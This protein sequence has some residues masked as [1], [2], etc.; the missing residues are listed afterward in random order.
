MTERR[1]R[2]FDGDSG[3]A[4]ALP[5]VAPVPR[6]NMTIRTATE[7]PRSA[8]LTLRPITTRKMV[9]NVA[10]I[11]LDGYA[12]AERYFE[13]GERPPQGG[14]MWRARKNLDKATECLHESLDL[15]R[16]VVLTVQG[17]QK[18]V[19]YMLTL[20]AAEAIKANYSES[21]ESRGE[22]L[23]AVRRFTGE[24]KDMVNKKNTVFGQ[25]YLDR[26]L[27]GKHFWDSPTNIEGS[28][29]SQPGYAVE[30]QTANSMKITE[31]MHQYFRESLNHVLDGGGYK[32]RHRVLAI[33]DWNHFSRRAHLCQPPT[34]LGF[35]L[36]N[37]GLEPTEKKPF[38][39]DLLYSSLTE[40][41]KAA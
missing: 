32:Y 15:E 11:Q 3:R 4:A 21:A 12:E 39:T 29:K 7:R 25:I 41:R 28:G 8:L 33:P 23:E 13:Q 40:G 22:I 10:K 30:K 38:H 26:K 5:L 37:C 1:S 34:G 17:T 14:F 6:R 27:R 19:G 2:S 31:R 16:S 9:E 24:S 18:V 35:E 20:P 36:M